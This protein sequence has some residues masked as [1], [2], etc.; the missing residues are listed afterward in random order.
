MALLDLN[1][2]AEFSGAHLVGEYS[3]ALPAVDHAS[4][5]SSAGPGALSFYSHPRHREALRHTQ[6]TAVLLREAD[7]AQ[8]PV[9]AL[10]CDDPYLG[11]ARALR[12][13]YPVAKVGHRIH[14]SSQISPQA[15]LES[16]VEIG[17][18]C[19]IEP[20]VR[21]GA[22][23]IL[24]PHCVIGAE[25]VVGEGCHLHGQVTLSG[26]AQLGD[27]V[28]VWSG[29]VIGSDGFGY[30]QE[31][32]RWVKL[33][34]QGSVRI[35]DDCE[36]GALVSIDRGMLDDTVIGCGV[37][38]DNQVQ[39]AH[40]VS[41]GDHSAIAGCAGIA[42]SATIGRYCQVGGAAG[43]QGHVELADGVIIT[44]MSKA[45]QSITEPGV[46]SSGTSIQEN[47]VW[48][49]NAVRFKQL[50]EI[51]CALRAGDKQ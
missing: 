30:A 15:H 24:G 21:I 44:G 41:I 8:C 13:L 18:Y 39:V 31:E 14:E 19:V 6:A 36:I 33:R 27:R 25:C 46:Y 40:N 22:N 17:P 43:V 26:A 10:L 1:Q 49:R 7:Q 42:G 37:K 50:D 9:P 35:G 4:S 2:I 20:G 51:A 32:R 29:T 38:I 47:A 28:E 16:P 11:M 34:H 5:L 23:T 45:N 12:A 48:L 3:D